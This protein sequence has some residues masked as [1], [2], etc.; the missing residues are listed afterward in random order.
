MQGDLMG[1]LPHVLGRKGSSLPQTRL[2]CP[3]EP[4]SSVSHICLQ[5]LEAPMKL[6]TSHCPDGLMNLELL[7]PPRRWLRGLGRVSI[8]SRSTREMCF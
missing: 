8:L 1:K 2:K 5:D 7:Q 4:V 6:T 3:W